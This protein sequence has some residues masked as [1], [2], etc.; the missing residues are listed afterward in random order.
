MQLGLGLGLNQTIGGVSPRNI[1]NLM[2]WLDASDLSTIT[3]TSGA[4]TQ[5]DDKSGR[6]NH[7]SQDIAAEQPTSGTRT[8]NGLNV[9]DFD[10]TGENFNIDH[11]DIYNLSNG[12]NTLFFVWKTDSTTDDQRL[13]TGYVSAATR[14]G[15]IYSLGTEVLLGQNATSYNPVSHTITEDTDV[16][17]ETLWRDGVDI[18]IGRDGGAVTTGANGLDVVTDR[19][20]IGATLGNTNDIDGVVCEI[21]AYGRNLSAAEKN[22]IGN[23]LAA[24]W[25]ATWSSVS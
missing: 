7:A 4:V 22:L 24:K 6:N 21:I 9:I 1:S 20:T 23:Y 19:A 14:Y 5:W 12:A 16:H 13:F 10:G 8:V 18:A 3:D 25:G 17:I 15:I 2:L 11:T